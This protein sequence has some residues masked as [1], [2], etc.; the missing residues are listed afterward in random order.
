MR[1]VI[2]SL[3][4]AAV[5]GLAV[6]ADADAAT[7]AKKKQRHAVSKQKTATEPRPRE[8]GTP[9]VSYMS[10]PDNYPV[11]SALWWQ[12]MERQGRSGFGEIP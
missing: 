9:E 10:S 11:G 4:A 1:I 8:G 7:V 3:V 12:A 5:A 6:S 2:V